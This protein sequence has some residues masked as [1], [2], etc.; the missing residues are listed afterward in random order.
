MW[1]SDG[2]S[3]SMN[4]HSIKTYIYY[5]SNTEI[6]TMEVHEM[7]TVS[8]TEMLRRIV[9]E[10]V[11]V[12][13]YETDDESDFVPDAS[14][15]VTWTRWTD[16]DGNK[17][18]FHVSKYLADFPELIRR[19]LEQSMRQIMGVEAPEGWYAETYRMFDEQR[20]PELVREQYMKDNRYIPYEGENYMAPQRAVLL[21][22]TLKEILVQVGGWNPEEIDWVRFVWSNDPRAVAEGKRSLRLAI[23]P[24]RHA[25][26]LVVLVEDAD[27]AARQALGRLPRVKPMDFS[28][29]KEQWGEE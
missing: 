28:K 17:V 7:T 15:R 8:Q 10:V 6:N 23:L 22:N 4:E 5:H 16:D 9:R 3:I 12:A 27:R 26:Y 14:I 20:F 24:V 21:E 25:K 1:S 2:Y 19:L 18:S 29:L 13:G 11:S